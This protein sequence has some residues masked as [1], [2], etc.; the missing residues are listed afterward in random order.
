MAA[1]PTII[2]IGPEGAGKS[3][4]GRLLAKRFSI[5]LYS[6]DR[7]RDELYA[8]YGYDKELAEKLFKE[9][10]IWS[11]WKYWSVFE[12]KAVCHILRNAIRPGDLF[13][14]KV[15]DFGAGHSVYEDESELKDVASLMAP[16]PNV[17]LLIPCEDEEEALRIMEQ[18]RGKALELN[19]LFVKHESN[20]FL[21]KH[22]VYTKDM[23]PDECEQQVVRLMQGKNSEYTNV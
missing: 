14:G 18:R 11:F 3:T 5:E 10:G 20:R 2:L 4:I 17:V 13:Y 21:A 9:E 22:V 6:L 1:N 7:H 19:K 8:P 16:F 23:T 15:L 12:F